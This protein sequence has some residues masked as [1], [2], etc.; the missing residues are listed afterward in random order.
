MLAGCAGAA[1]KSINLAERPEA[2]A[3]S[4]LRYYL[5]TTYLKVAVTAGYV[6]S[7]GAP[8][9]LSL[10]QLKVEILGG[11]PAA[12][13]STPYLLVIK[14]SS[15]SDDHHCF[16]L[17][18]N[19][20]LKTVDYVGADRTGDILTSLAGAAAV[21]VTPVP[22][23]PPVETKMVRVP[24]R[25][26]WDANP[27]VEVL[28]NPAE[29]ASL[30]DA[31]KIVRRALS[32]RLRE[33]EISNDYQAKVIASEPRL[34]K[35]IKNGDDLI[36]VRAAD[37][38]SARPAPKEASGVV[39]RIPVKRLYVAGPAI[40]GTGV[41]RSAHVLGPDA[42]GAG[43]IAITRASFTRKET[44]LGLSNGMLVSVDI[45]KPSQA[46][47]VASLP[48]EIAEAV[49][50][51]PARFFTTI[52]SSFKSEANLLSARAELLQ[53]QAAL[54]EIRK[55]GEATVPDGAGL[56]DQGV[57]IG[58]KANPPEKFNSELSCPSQSD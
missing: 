57:P 10:D 58:P 8:K 46:L 15:R 20:L 21:L 1:V 3:Q 50:E 45:N 7:E 52:A 14:S 56:T 24:Q 26:V 6:L 38:A 11:E 47:A 30:A 54:E 19:G 44:Q 40:D 37:D 49:I 5:P 4:G 18:E 34:D 43:W 22:G 23:A 31:Q 53:A 32:N 12:D 13:T 35:A 48:L 55:G 2:A 25:I 27:F 41:D 39:Y 29:D 42:L 28:V 17:N 51:T 36:S 9:T 16:V 33:L